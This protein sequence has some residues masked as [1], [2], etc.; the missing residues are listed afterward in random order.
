MQCYQTTKNLKDNIGNY[1]DIAF[2]PTMGNLHEGHLRLVE[3]AKSLSKNVVVSIFINPIQF[4]SKKDFDAYPKTLTTDKDLL[5]S[6]YAD[7]IIFSP[8]EKD[9]ISYIP[10]KQYALPELAYDLCG[11]YRPGH[12][13]GVIHIINILFNLIQPKFAVFGKKDYQQLK[14]IEK[15]SGE[16]YPTINIIKEET[17]RALDFLAL[18]SRNN[19]LKGKYKL[20]ANELYLALKKLIEMVKLTKNFDAVTK[21]IITSLNG[22][23]WD[24]EYISVRNQSNLKEPSSKDTNLVVLA[25]AKL[26]NVRLIDN[27][28]FC[29]D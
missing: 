7:S 22:S 23:G 24:V 5:K 15:F 6:V 12:F 3:R 13:N 11:K 26:N 29:I 18:S 28:E 25:A 20:K 21:E 10:F 2:V 17:V 16:Y 8:N 19:L 1:N 27:I 4:N 14:L 9:I